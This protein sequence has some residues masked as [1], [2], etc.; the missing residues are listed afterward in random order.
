MVFEKKTVDNFW[1]LFQK[2]HYINPN[3][4]SAISAGFDRGFAVSNFKLA[5]V[6][7]QNCF[8]KRGL[9]TQET[10]DFANHAFISFVIGALVSYSRSIMLGKV[11]LGVGKKTRKSLI[12]ALLKDPD[13]SKAIKI[14]SPSKNESQLIPRAIA[15]KCNKLLEFACNNRAKEIL[16]IRRKV[17][18]S[19]RLS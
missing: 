15:W 8:K 12:E 11:D 19:P 9:S 3:I 4:K 13:I 6:R 14:Y 1:Y 5:K 17:T 7:I 16:R 18:S 10:E 2:S